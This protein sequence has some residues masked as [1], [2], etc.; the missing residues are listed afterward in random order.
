MAQYLNFDLSS[1]VD[2]QSTSDI[3]GSDLLQITVLGDGNFSLSGS[4]I[5][6]GLNNAVT[7]TATDM[8]GN[9]NVLIDNTS[10]GIKNVSSGT[11]DDVIT[12]DGTNQSSTGVVVN[13]NGGS[14]DISLTSN[15][16]GSLSKISLNGGSEIDQVNF[17]S[18][19][20]FSLSDLTLTNIEI[21]NFAGGTASQNS[22]RCSFYKIYILSKSGS[23]TLYRAIPKAQTIDLSS[24]T[25]DSSFVVGSDVIIIDGT[26]FGQALNVTGSTSNDE[27]TGTHSSGDTISSGNGDDT[28]TAEMVTTP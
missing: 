12:I 3:T 6:G 10:N 7:M 27:I 4:T 19:L 5:V 20:D 13:S 26:N 16:D 18:E 24:L 23:N 25:F 1:G 9:L 15:S 8:T 14:D 17:E 2:F 11:G 21:L 22:I 28:Y